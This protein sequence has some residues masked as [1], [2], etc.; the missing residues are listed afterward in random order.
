M[1]A[2]WLRGRGLVMAM[3]PFVVGEGFCRGSGFHVTWLQ[4]VCR[5]KTN[6]T[7]FASRLAQRLSGWAAMLCMHSNST[8]CCDKPSGTP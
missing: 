8:Q 5:C 7:Y 2:C 3:M 6:D 1:P 4:V